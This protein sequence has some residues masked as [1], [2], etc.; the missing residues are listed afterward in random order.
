LD[1]LE[2]KRTSMHVASNIEAKL[3]HSP[4]EDFPE[5]ISPAIVK[6]LENEG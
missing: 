2:T 5:A 4:Q 1:W 6:F 3:G